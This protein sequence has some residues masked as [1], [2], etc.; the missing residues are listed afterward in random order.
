VKAFLRGLGV[1]AVIAGLILLVMGW[2]D[3]NGC[4][5]ALSGFVAACVPG[6]P[7]RAAA[8][9]DAGDMLIAGWV[10]LACGIA[11]M[12]PVI[13]LV[14]L[15][16]L[17]LPVAFCCG[18]RPGQEKKQAPPLAGEDAAHARYQAQEAEREQARRSAGYPGRHSAV[19]QRVVDTPPVTV[20]SFAERLAAIAH[21]SDEHLRRADFQQLMREKTTKGLPKSRA[22]T[23]APPVA[24]P[25]E[26]PW[27]DSSPASDGPNHSGGHLHVRGFSRRGWSVPTKKSPAEPYPELSA[28]HYRQAMAA[29]I[30]MNTSL[31]GSSA[32][33]LKS[34]LGIKGEEARELLAE[35]AGWRARAEGPIPECVDDR[36]R[37]LAAGRDGGHGAEA[38]AACGRSARVAGADRGHGYDGKGRWL[39]SE[40]KELQRVPKISLACLAWVSDG[41]RGWGDDTPGVTEGS[42]SKLSTSPSDSRTTVNACP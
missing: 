42:C 26:Y 31:N 34:W 41:D 35:A 2:L 15:L 36:G 23:T 6:S 4:G 11:L 33:V 18:W 8:L 39:D 13:L 29:Y 24:L 16:P 9:A 22:F 21:I 38:E 5:G 7:A 32:S 1:L 20:L 28:A 25:G 40:D 14:P 30:T 37:H 19:L 27:E 17:I 3:G 12:A 10:T